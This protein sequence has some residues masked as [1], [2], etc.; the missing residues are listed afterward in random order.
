MT[1]RVHSKQVA[2]A[3]S[4][5]CQTSKK[6]SIAKISNGWK[7]LPTLVKRSIL[8]VLQSSECASG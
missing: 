7:L 8:N 1:E 2:K 6:E 5:L 3:Y 4:E